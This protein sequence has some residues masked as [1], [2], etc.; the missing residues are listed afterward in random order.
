MQIPD[1]LG[2]GKK[3]KKNYYF[4]R[5]IISYNTLFIYGIERSRMEKG[6]EQE[7]GSLKTTRVTCFILFEEKLV[8]NMIE[9]GLLIADSWVNFF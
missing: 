6:V 2:D 8:I 3:K 1:S 5:A 9:D 7:F 4:E